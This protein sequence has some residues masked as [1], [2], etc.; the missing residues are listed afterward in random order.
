LQIL[1]CGIDAGA[2]H[3]VFDRRNSVRAQP[4]YDPLLTRN[5]DPAT[6][7]SDE[8]PFMHQVAQR[9]S[10]GDCA[11]LELDSQL[12]DCRQLIAELVLTG[13]DP[14]PQKMGY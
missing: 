13:V 12:L 4:T 5:K 14:R 9:A 11:D 10:H 1:D 6:L 8:K 3:I 7:S 2:A